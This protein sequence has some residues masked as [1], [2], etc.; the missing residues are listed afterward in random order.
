MKALDF[1]FELMKNVWVLRPGKKAPL[2]DLMILVAIQRGHVTRKAI[3]ANIPSNEGSF[4]GAIRSLVRNGYIVQ[5]K[6][7]VSR[8]E[9]TKRG[10]CVIAELFTVK[11]HEY[12][13]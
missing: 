13:T 3:L 1:G 6:D 2:L 4:F 10:E 9:V 8:Y 5:V 12:H 7:G 11:K